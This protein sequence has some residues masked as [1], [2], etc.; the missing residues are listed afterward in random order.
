[1]DI[2]EYSIEQFGAETADTYFLGFDEA[3]DL[4]ARHPLAGEAKQKIGKGIRCLTHRQHR[5]FY[6]VDKDIVLI[7]RIIHHARDAKRA[8]KG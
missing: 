6:I 7:I 1:M 4:L 3:F 2:R 8:L 5:I